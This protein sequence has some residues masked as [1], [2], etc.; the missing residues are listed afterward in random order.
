MRAGGMDT[1]PS[2]CWEV[3]RVGGGGGR[4]GGRQLQFVGDPEELIALLGV[5]QERLQLVRRCFGQDELEHLHLVELELADEA[6]G[7]LAGA[8]LLI[9]EAGSVGDVAEG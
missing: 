2:A 9:P 5:R 1:E 7:L 4:G 8:E 6:A 3:S